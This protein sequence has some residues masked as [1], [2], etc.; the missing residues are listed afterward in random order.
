MKLAIIILGVILGLACG[1][2][3]SW[4]LKRQSMAAGL[5]A[6]IAVFLVMSAALFA[7]RAVARDVLVPFGV[8]AVLSFL[9][10]AVASALGACRR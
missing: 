9:G 6:V 5:G 4:A 3:V 7:V 10:V 1:A 8:L 2:A